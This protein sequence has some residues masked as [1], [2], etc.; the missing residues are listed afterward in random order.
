M[1]TRDRT[2]DPYATEAKEFLRK[3]L[4]GRDVEVK[5]EYTRKI[6]GTAGK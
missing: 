4:V 3:K 2:A 6:P 1:S 5:M